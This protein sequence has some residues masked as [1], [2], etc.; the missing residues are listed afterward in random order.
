MPM[1]Q[2]ICKYTYAFAIHLPAFGM[3]YQHVTQ[4]H[5]DQ[6]QQRQTRYEQHGKCLHR[7]HTIVDSAKALPCSALICCSHSRPTT[8]VVVCCLR[9]AFADHA[10]CH[11]Q[12]S[13]KSSSDFYRQCRRHCLSVSLS[14]ASMSFGFMCSPSRATHISND[15]ETMLLGT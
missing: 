7:L 9:R 2:N 10:E 11:S 6:Q 1:I 14:L 15:V 5:Q 8:A 13:S 4:R 3:E 12:Y